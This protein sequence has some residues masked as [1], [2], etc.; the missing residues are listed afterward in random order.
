MLR[1]VFIIVRFRNLKAGK[2]GRCGGVRVQAQIRRSGGGKCSRLGT[3]KWDGSHENRLVWAN[4]S[5]STRRKWCVHK[6]ISVSEDLA[7]GLLSGSVGRDPKIELKEQ[8]KSP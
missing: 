5:G 3:P 8:T 6:S 1:T 7:N 4:E 2:F